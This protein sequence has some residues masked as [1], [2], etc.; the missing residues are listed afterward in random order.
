MELDRQIHR[1]FERADQFCG[2][3]WKQQ[4][5][6]IFE[7]DGIC[8]HI[9]DLLGYGGPV[10]DGV[11]IPQGIGQGYLGMAFFLIGRCHGCLQIAQV[12]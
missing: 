4:A 5:R 11:G 1:V 7:T 9:L 12:V 3:I 10:V 6:H 8:P 2:M